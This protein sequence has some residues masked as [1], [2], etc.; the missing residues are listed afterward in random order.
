MDLLMDLA[1]LFSGLN[2]VVLIALI[3]IYGRIAIRS[4]AVL[5]V[6]LTVF[7]V[8]LLTQNFL[9]LY[10]YY[11]MEPLFGAETV[12]ILSTTSVLQFIAYTILLKFTI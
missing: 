6:A 5:S 1:I 9:S 2:V 10:A 3:Y 11:A 4:K 7:A 12:P 8:V